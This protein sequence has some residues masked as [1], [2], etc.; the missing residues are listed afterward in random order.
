[1]TYGKARI[2]RCNTSWIPVPGRS[3]F[4]SQLLTTTNANNKT[5]MPYFSRSVHHFF[6]TRDPFAR[7][8][9]Q[10]EKRAYHR[11]RIRSA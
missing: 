9:C 11:C 8:P 2:G 6:F 5:P 7:Q 10:L 3:G 4:D 1:M